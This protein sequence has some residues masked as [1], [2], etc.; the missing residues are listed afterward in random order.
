MEETVIGIGEPSGESMALMAGHT[1]S[2]FEACDCQARPVDPEQE[3]EGITVVEANANIRVTEAVEQRVVDDVL[4]EEY[5]EIEDEPCDEGAPCDEGRC[6]DD[7]LYSCA[8][9]TTIECE[10]SDRR[11]LKTI[12]RKEP[13]RLQVEYVFPDEGEC[14]SYRVREIFNQYKSEMMQMVAKEELHFKYHD[15][16]GTKEVV[17]PAGTKGGYVWKDAMVINSW[18]D[19]RSVVYGSSVENCYLVDTVINSRGYVEDSYLES[20][21]CEQ[22]INLEVRKSTLF[23][24][25]F[26]GEECFVDKSYLM[27][28][29][30]VGSRLIKCRNVRGFEIIR[31]KVENV[32]DTTRFIVDGAGI[33]DADRDFLQVTNVGSARRTVCAYKTPR[34]G[35][36]VSTG[37]FRG[38]LE[39]LTIANAESHLGYKKSENGYLVKS[40][41]NVNRI[42][43]WCYKE[44]DMLIKYIKHHF[45][46]DINTMTIP[47]K[48]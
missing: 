24:V 35:V 14:L 19:D 32:S 9:I 41:A 2:A 13:K 47:T 27:N 37:C 40:R 4:E 18:I 34:G 10:K 48:Y 33:K 36:R 26:S 7:Y 43:E 17:I 44:Y 29:D 38:T 6:E 5:L 46:L 16:K 23:S 28:G 42:D 30:I 31:S 25:I 45:K 11:C 21:R 39:E 22:Y 3:T 8:G 12:Q 15:G 1:A 20:C